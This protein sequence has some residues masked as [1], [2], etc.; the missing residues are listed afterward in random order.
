[1]TGQ[2]I[3]RSVSNAKALYQ[4]TRAATEPSMSYSIPPHFRPLL[5]LGPGWRSQYSDC[6]TDWT[7]LSL[8]PRRSKRFIAVSGFHTS[9][10]GFS[11]AVKRPG[12]E[13][14]YSECFMA[15]IETILSLLLP[16]QYYLPYK[17][18]S[19]KYFFFWVSR[20][21]FAFLLR[22]LWYEFRAVVEESRSRLPRPAIRTVWA[23][24]MSGWDTRDNLGQISGGVAYDKMQ[25][26]GRS[27]KESGTVRA[28]GGTVC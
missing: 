27:C 19:Y 16:Y 2:D 8:I 28:R 1:V 4:D 21:K 3:S 10:V 23:A 5:I 22:T 13:A 24:C 26:T 12:L 6:A 15:F 11:L 14:H 25:M 18:R 7:V 9:S 20:L 17:S